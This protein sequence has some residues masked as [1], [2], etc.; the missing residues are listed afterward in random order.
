MHLII[1]QRPEQ[2]VEANPVQEIVEKAAAAFCK[3][4]HQFQKNMAVLVNT[5]MISLD[6]I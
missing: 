4:G 2:E 5:T 1:L 3:T 6:M